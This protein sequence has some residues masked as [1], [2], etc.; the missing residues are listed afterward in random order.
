[1]FNAENDIKKWGPVLEHADA[2]AITDNYRKAVT[3]KL[4]ENTEVALK[5]ESAQLGSLKENMQSS[6]TTVQ[7]ST[8]FSS[9]LYVVQCLTLSP[10]M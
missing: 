1:M 5:Q 2:P 8:Q 7:T 6:A 9:R 3:A 10:T 4:L